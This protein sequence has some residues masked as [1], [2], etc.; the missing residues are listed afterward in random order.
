MP[1]GSAPIIFETARL[2]V[3]QYTEE[4]AG[5][6][7][8]L[9]GN[10]DV[11]QYIRPV[12]TREQSDAFLKEN[13]DYY[14]NNPTRGRWAV[15]E[16]E[17]RV[18]VGSFAIIPLPSQPSELQ[19]GYSLTPENWGK[20]YATELTLAGLDYFLKQETLPVIY[21]VTETPNIASQ[22]VL[23]KAGFEP[24]GI[25]P[26]GEKELLLFRVNR[27]KEGFAQGFKAG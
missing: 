21:G 3:R 22:K 16:K 26:E 2:R 7:F 10:A 13:I 18:F 8:L 19:L 17:S 14:R 12:S 1:A 4:D 25:L 20:G 27:R 24:A 15:E 23:L 6:F 5:L 11:M 9:S